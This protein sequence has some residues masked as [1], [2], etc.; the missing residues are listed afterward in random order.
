MPI[1]NVWDNGIPDTS[2]DGNPNDARF[3]I[4]IKP[5]KE[6]LAKVVARCLAAMERLTGEIVSEKAR[7]DCADAEEKPLDTSDTRNSVATL[8]S[9]GGFKF[10]VGGDLTW[11]TEASLVCPVDRV[12]VVDVYQVNHHG[13]D[14]SNNLIL[15]QSL[16]PAVSVVSNGTRK[17]VWGCSFATLDTT[18]LIQA[19]YQIHKNLRNDSQNDTPPNRSRILRKTVMRTTSRC[20]LHRM[21]KRTQS[22]T[23]EP[24]IHGS[25][26]RRKVREQRVH[27]FCRRTPRCVT[28]TLQM[29]G[30]A[31][32]LMA[33]FCN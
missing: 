12:G 15:L 5:Y 4:M 26:R 29:K 31:R 19:I 8:I 18:S 25:S 23:R 20:L 17:R 10:F 16:S 28:R 32:W 30:W 6:M 33:R 3:P 9:V 22:P 13:L 11:N 24:V 7:V 2:P 14:M 21:A 27:Y 1:V